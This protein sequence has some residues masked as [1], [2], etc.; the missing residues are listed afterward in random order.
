MVR[1]LLLPSAAWTDYAILGSEFDEGF[2]PSVSA[3]AL[4][5]LH[6]PKGWLMR[7]RPLAR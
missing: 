3:L 6:V 7:N 2:Y 1:L 4:L 5:L